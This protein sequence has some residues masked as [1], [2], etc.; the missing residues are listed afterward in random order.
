MEIV[1]IIL[2][3]IIQGVTEF[4]PISSTAHLILVAELFSE[5]GAYILD[6][7][8]LEIALHFGTL[9]AVIIYF[10]TELKAIAISP[11]SSDKQNK[12]L[13]YLLA[14]ATLPIA[15]VGFFVNDYVELLRNPILIAGTTFIFGLLLIVAE[16]YSKERKISN[17]T[18]KDS[19]LI[20]I[21]EVLALIPGVS[22]SGVT[23]T[24]A[25]ALGFTR[26]DA[27]KFSFLLSIPTITGAIILKLKDIAL[28]EIQ[29]DWL[30]IMTG[31]VVTFISATLV[32]HYLLKFIQKI[33]FL[34]FFI[35]RTIISIAILMIFL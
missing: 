19:I 5:K 10:S 28:D 23:S 22:R 14:V 27:L 11:F 4:L 31:I 9:L 7:F 16:R 6:G 30:V 34:P 1:F 35:Y 25:M 13:L 21:S 26:S 15:F 24:S 32:I 33:G 20:G 29:I 17:L 8:I 3:G 2:L 18:L 12:K